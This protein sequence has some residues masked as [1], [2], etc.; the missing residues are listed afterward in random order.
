MKRFLRTL[1]VAAFVVLLGHHRPA[2][3]QPSPPPGISRFGAVTPGDCVQWHSNTQIADSGGACGGGGGS[4]SI[5]AADASVVV[6]PS[7]LTGTGTVKVNIASNT[8]GNCVQWGTGKQLMAAAAPCGSGG[9]GTAP[10]QITISSTGIVTNYAT[11]FPSTS[12]TVFTV[13]KR[14]FVR[15]VTLRPTT[16][17]FV[18]CGIVRSDGLAGYLLSWQT[19]GH[20]ILKRMD[21]GSS[22]TIAT[23][24][25]A[26]GN[27]A[28]YL[29]LEFT[30]VPDNA[31]SGN[32]IFGHAVGVAETFN[33]DTTYNL[34]SGTWFIAVGAAAFADVGEASFTVDAN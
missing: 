14:L 33:A 2:Y 7:P 19:D 4:V 10:T 1:F 9:G 30:V 34:T 25:T 18:A 11:V 32:F 15:C 17:D 6:T 20:V 22:A 27:G 23:A 12:A 28:G 29:V 21:N 3:G 31:H 5:T 24:T 8:D 26:A 13:G 16:G